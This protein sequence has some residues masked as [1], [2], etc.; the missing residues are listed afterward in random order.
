MK[1]MK[2]VNPD[3]CPYRLQKGYLSADYTGRQG[4]KCFN[5]DLNKKDCSV[6]H[7]FR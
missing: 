2:F 3:L 5:G 1:C 6:S 4:V 7:R